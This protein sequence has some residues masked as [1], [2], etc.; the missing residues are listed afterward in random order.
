MRLYHNRTKLSIPLKD[1]T[2]LWLV[3]LSC[4]DWRFLPCTGA[5]FASIPMEEGRWGYVPVN[6]QLRVMIGVA[7][8]QQRVPS[9]LKGQPVLVP[10]LLHAR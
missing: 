1:S 7:R 4:L 10:G 8:N 2:A 6:K 3:A 9:L 5:F